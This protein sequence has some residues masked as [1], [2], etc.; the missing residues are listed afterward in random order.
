[1]SFPS[2]L[3]FASIPATVAGV[4]RYRWYA[5]LWVVAL[6]SLFLA[7]AGGVFLAAFGL[8][9]VVLGSVRAVVAHR[10]LDGF[11]GV[12]PRLDPDPPDLTHASAMRGAA[13]TTAVAAGV[14]LLVDLVTLTRPTGWSHA[15]VSLCMAIAL[16]SDTTALANQDFVTQRLV[17]ALHLRGLFNMWARVFGF[18]LTKTGGVL[19][20]P[21]VGVA[22]ALAAV[23]APLAGAEVMVAATWP[24]QPE[25]TA[26]TSSRIQWR[27]RT[28]ARSKTSNT[29]ITRSGS[30]RTE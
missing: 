3:T 19:K 8:V 2:W 20:P 14:L 30:R 6:V 9:Y 17:N 16:I 4:L 10:V 21:S 29:A 15:V 11:R 22:V 24:D 23:V 26:G 25:R 5:A 12:A 28:T 27:K 1:M 7:G 13:V 18:D